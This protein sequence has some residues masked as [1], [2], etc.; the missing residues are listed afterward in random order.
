MSVWPTAV[1]RGDESAVKRAVATVAKVVVVGEA[2]RLDD[3]AKLS[4]YEFEIDTTHAV[5]AWE[6]EV[7]GNMARK[8][9]AKAAAE[10]AEAEG[11]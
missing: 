5:Q 3:T 6:R 4:R 7:A 2:V 8:A 10:A 11:N 9:E 1:I